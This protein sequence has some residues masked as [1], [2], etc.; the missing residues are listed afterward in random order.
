MRMEIQIEI[1]ML[2]INKIINLLVIFVQNVNDFMKI[3]RFI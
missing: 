3:M 2:G 1:G